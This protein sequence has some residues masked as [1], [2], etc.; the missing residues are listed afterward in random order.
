MRAEQNP[1]EQQRALRRLNQDALAIA[2]R[3]SWADLRQRSE[4]TWG[5]SALQLPSNLAGI[6]LVWDDDNGI[7]YIPRNRASGEQEENAFR[8]S[9]YA[10]GSP[11]ATATDASLTQDSG[12]LSSTTLAA[13]GSLIVGEYFYVD[14]EPQMYLISA[15]DDV[16]DLY[17]FTP[18][19]RGTGTKSSARVTVRPPSTQ[20]LI[21]LAP[22]GQAVPTGSFT[23][24]YWKMPDTLRDA[25]DIVPF[26]TAEVLTFR[27]ISRLPEARKLRPISQAQVDGALAEALAINPDK[28]LPRLA[29]GIQGRRIDFSRNHYSP[30][31][32]E[33]VRVNRV[34]DTWR[35]NH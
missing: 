14:G 6:D 25:H 31:S 24:H 35:Q 11:Y 17:T 4:L 27:A 10:V 8:Y 21:L 1:E 13:A 28:P 32:N 5:G 33:N 16:T 3:D 9:T 2:L 12:T 34:Y 30:R 20:M 29:K 23:L 18:A 15:F 22:E 19:Y 7:E 26:P